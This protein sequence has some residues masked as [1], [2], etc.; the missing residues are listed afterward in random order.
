ML[1]KC[2]G[3]ADVHQLACYLD[4]LPVATGA[5]LGATKILPI[6]TETAA[7]P[8]LAWRIPKGPESEAQRARVGV[9]DLSADLGAT[10]KRDAAGHSGP[11]ELARA[12]C[13]SLRRQAL[14]FWRSIRSSPIF[15]ISTGWKPEAREAR[16]DGFH[17]KMA[18]HPNQVEVINRAFAVT[19]EERTWAKAWSPLSRA[20]RAKAS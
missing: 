11:F 15:T 14:V 12:T 10:R 6:V 9:E 13:V 16:A 17:A 19:A 18:I 1:P 8:G 20:N 5:A 7:S 4:P 2:T 3:P